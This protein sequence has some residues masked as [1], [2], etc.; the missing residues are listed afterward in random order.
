MFLSAYIVLHCAA[1]KHS[2]L[3]D[4]L[5]P[6]S[7]N[8]FTKNYSNKNC[9]LNWKCS[10]KDAL[11]L[12]AMLNIQTGSVCNLITLHDLKPELHQVG[13]FTYHGK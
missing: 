9:I 4:K 11:R 2:A 1:F 7:N 6:G 12:T 3:T 5:T 8:T 10:F 13:K